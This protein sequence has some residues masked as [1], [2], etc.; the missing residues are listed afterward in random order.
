MGKAYSGL[1]DAEIADM[2]RWFEA[3][4]ISIHGRYRVVEPTVVVEIAFDIIQRSTRHASGYAMR[5][6]RIVRIRDD[7]TAARGRPA[8]DGGGHRATR[9]QA[10]GRYQV[11]TAEQLSHAGLPTGD[12]AAR[13]P[14]P[15][16]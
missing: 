10:G 5:F 3:N 12:D 8:V 1:T 2:T 13:G 9:L 11:L 15:A 14:L 4:T 16:R 6:P 7:K